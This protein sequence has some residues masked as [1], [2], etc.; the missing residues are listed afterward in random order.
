MMTKKKNTIMI[1]LMVVVIIYF[2][3]NTDVFWELVRGC[4]NS[5]DAD[6]T[7]ATYGRALG[8]VLPDPDPFVALASASAR[9]SVYEIRAAWSIGELAGGGSAA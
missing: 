7:V 8:A 5:P 2:F 1:F 3:H 9:C 4:A 6:Q